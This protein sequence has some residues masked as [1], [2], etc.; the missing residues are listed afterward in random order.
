MPASS[1]FYF[2]IYATINLRV[3]ISQLDISLGKYS[4]VPRK[5]LP[6]ITLMYDYQYRDKNPE[7]KYIGSNSNT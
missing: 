7:R 4:L 5:L 3:L 2:T 6:K 1:K